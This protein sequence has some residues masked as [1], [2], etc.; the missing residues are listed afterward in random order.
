[1]SFSCFYCVAALEN[2]FFPKNIK[3]A[4]GGMKNK[5]ENIC[6]F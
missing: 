1:M 3:L 6:K 5:K 4:K 2:L